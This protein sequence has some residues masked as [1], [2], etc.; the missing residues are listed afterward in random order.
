MTGNAALPLSG[1]TLC[2]LIIGAATCSI[3]LLGH[4]ERNYYL[5][6]GL[7]WVFLTIIFEFGMG[8]LVMKSSLADLFRAYDVATGNLWLLVVVVMGLA[9]LVSAKIR[10]LI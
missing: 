4:K 3:H 1:I 6:I 9:P 2:F 7:Y 8:L 10:G 5:I